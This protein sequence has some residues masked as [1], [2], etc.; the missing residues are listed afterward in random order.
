MKKIIS[1]IAI[2]GIAL[3]SVN[4]YTSDMLDSANELAQREVI[5]DNSKNPSE[6]NLDDN[7]LRQ[8]IALISRRVS[9]HDANSS[10]KNLFSDVSAS[11]P[12]DWAC[13]NIEALVE[14]NLISANPSFRPEDY[15]SKSEALI[16]FIKSIGFEDFEIDSSSPKNWQQQVVEFAVSKWVVDNFT[17]YNT[18]ATRGWVFQI[19]NFTIKVKEEEV[20]KKK[21]LEK[22]LISDEA[23]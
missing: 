17:D 1:S 16:M 3:S 14:N 7:V 20:R 5:K 19:A 23:L 6:Y 11:Q 22:E 13:I 18:L 8:E 12:N 4:A 10:C 2:L 15:I 9:W 21:E